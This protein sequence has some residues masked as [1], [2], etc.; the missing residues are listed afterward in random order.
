MKRIMSILLVLLLALALLPAAAFAEGPTVVLS[1]QNLRV[2]GKPIE[3]EKYNIDGSNYFKLRDLAYVLNGTGS[4]F[5][6]AWDGANKCVSLVTGEAYE[7]NGSELDLSGGDK[8]DTAAPSLDSIMVNGELRTDLSAY[9]IG[10]NNY[11][12]LRD[13]GGALGF[14][15]DYDQPS[16]TMIV[17]SYAWA[18]PT[19]WLTVETVYNDDGAATAHSVYTYD[20]SG[21]SLTGLYEDA[22]GTETTACTYDELGRQ[23]T[24]TYDYTPF[25]EDSWEEHSTTTYHYDKWGLLTRTVY[26][27]VGDVVNETNYGYDDN[28]NMI[29]EETVSNSGRYGYYYTYDEN[30]CLIRSTYAE[31]DE[32]QYTTEYVRD[33][34]G[35]AVQTRMIDSDGEVL[36][37]TESTYAD[38]R[39][40]E[41]AYSSGDFWSRSRYTYDEMGNTVRSESEDSY[42]NTQ[43][44]TNI[45]DEENHLV[46]EEYNSG[47]YSNIAVY[48]YNAQ[49]LMTKYEV[50]GSDGSYYEE[51]YTYDEEGNIL[52][53]VCRSDGITYTITYTYDL[54]ENKLTILHLTEYKAVG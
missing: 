22:Y 40:A 53:D 35:Y 30:G 39:L 21:H 37:T 1:G 27:A 50:T 25:D 5:S 2:N 17:V 12:K 29:L 47:S 36:S 26:E 16:S 34:D 3:C 49:G 13:L 38:G 31:E 43:V 24:W 28:G 7:P 48:T 18:Y 52:T 42:G 33:A 20:E 44:S 46:Q 9:K 41:S 15:V 10:G 11:F 19:P 14:Y 32:V 23:V 54:A 51:E 45:Y 8:S 4:Q 6:V